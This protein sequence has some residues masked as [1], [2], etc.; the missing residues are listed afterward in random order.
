MP[1]PNT[2]TRSF[3]PT[4]RPFL[5]AARSVAAVAAGLMVNVVLTTATDFALSALSVF[6]PFETGFSASGLVVLALS[7]RTLF[8]AISGYATARLAPDSPMRHARW[9]M[10]VG[11]AIGLLSVFGGW[12][13]FPHWYLIGIVVYSVIAV[14]F[15]AKVYAPRNHEASRSRSPD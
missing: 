3:P 14:W 13:M 12:K 10:A 4:K 1:Q 2:M 8:A 5:L 6:P 9:L 7:Y 15:G 11:T